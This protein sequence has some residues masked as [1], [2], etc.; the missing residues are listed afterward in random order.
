MSNPIRGFNAI[1]VE[2]S[3]SNPIRGFNA[4]LVVQTR[5]SH[6]AALFP[7]IFPTLEQSLHTRIFDAGFQ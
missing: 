4:I 5:F 1:L 6:Y 2:Q 7:S 3:M